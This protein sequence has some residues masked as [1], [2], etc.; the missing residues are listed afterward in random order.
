VKLT[1]ALALPGVTVPIV[2]A[3][4]TVIGVTLL[5]AADAG[6]VPYALV[7]V[8]VNVYAV[9][10]VSP[11]TDNGLV[12]PVAVKP[13]GLDVAVYDVIGP[14]PVDTGAV[15]GTVARALPAVAVPIVG[16]P[17]AAWKTIGRIISFSS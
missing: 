14:E 16:A 13:P 15:K 5:E 7:A 17:G 11:V 10:F 12:V 2:G 8:T 4:G 1:T 3:P 6:P 9:P